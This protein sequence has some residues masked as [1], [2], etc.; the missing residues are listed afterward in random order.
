MGSSI[1]TT[2]GRDDAKVRTKQERKLQEQGNRTCTRTHR[3]NSGAE[4]NAHSTS[5]SHRHGNHRNAL[6][7][8]A[9]QVQHND[10]VQ[11]LRRRV[12]DQVDARMLHA[13]HNR[14][15]HSVL[16]PHRGVSG[17]DNARQHSAHLRAEGD[18][19]GAERVA[20]ALVAEQAQHAHKRLSERKWAN[21]GARSE[22]KRQTRAPE[23]E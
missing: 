14:R 6:E 10:C 1:V 12:E 11:A 13:Q 7:S 23:S 15:A 16:R 22:L 8:N 18:I 2:R 9:L 5:I 3:S 4:R 21:T 19:D 20:V 17:A